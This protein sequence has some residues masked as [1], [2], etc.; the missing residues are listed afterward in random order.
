MPASLG[1]ADSLS[2][3]FIV[4]LNIYFNFSACKFFTFSFVDVVNS[5]VKLLHKLEESE[6]IAREKVH[7]LMMGTES[8]G[9]A[10]EKNDLNA[11][12]IGFTKGLETLK[13]LIQQLK[14]QKVRELYT[15]MVPMNVELNTKLG[16]PGGSFK[17]VFNFLD[18]ILVRLQPVSKLATDYFWYNLKQSV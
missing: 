4:F 18:Y 13:P 2:G 5:L 11:A 15:S 6:A 8:V 1:N 12:R 16:S 14:H 10:A 3:I 9:K 17:D 7:D